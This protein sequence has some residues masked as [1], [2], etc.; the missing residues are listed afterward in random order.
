MEALANCAVL[1]TTDS[2]KLTWPAGFQ[3]QHATQLVPSN[4]QTLPNPSPF[5]VPLTGPGEFFRVIPL[6]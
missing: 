2:L 6:P 1:N 3:L 4:W 5:T